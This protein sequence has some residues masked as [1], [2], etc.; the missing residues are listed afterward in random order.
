MLRVGL[1]L[2]ALVLTG[3]CATGA[4]D[5]ARSACKT[6]DSYLGLIALEDQPTPEQM[7]GLAED[8]AEDDEQFARLAVLLRDWADKGQANIALTQRHGLRDMPPEQ[9]RIFD[10]RGK[11]IDALTSQISEECKQARQ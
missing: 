10:Q 1:A 7:V 5:S 9:R 8:A 6:F 2:L 3:G 4:N 11:E